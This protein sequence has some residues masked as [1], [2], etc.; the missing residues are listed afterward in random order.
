[1]APLFS[2]IIPV[3]NVEE[4]LDECLDSVL[5]QM[6]QDVSSLEI[7]LVDD[8]STDNSGVICD[9]YG[10]LHENIKVIHQ[11][12]QGLLGAR[13]TGYKSASG[14]YIINLDS[15]DL[16]AEKAVFSLMDAVNK[17]DADIVFFNISV[18][19]DA[20]IKPYYKDVFTSRTGC[21]ISKDQVVKAYF[22]YDIPVVTSMAGKIIKKDCFDIEY[23][24]SK[25]GRLSMGEDT[26]QTAEVVS[27][28]TT[29]YYLNQNLYIYRM[30]SGMTAKFDP[31]FYITFKQIISEVRNR[32]GFADKK[33]YA[34]FYNEKIVSSGCRAITQSKG[35][36]MRYLDRKKYIKGI[37][38]DRD[39]KNALSE[40]D[41]RTANIKNRY[42][43]IIWLSSIHAYLLIHVT[44]KLMR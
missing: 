15:D 4:Y 17:T 11:N 21:F 24:Y 20:E 22:N 42:K 37:I 6:N 38:K 34:R 27:R 44:L 29:Y 23:D 8:G 39:F 13:R 25:F 1:M 5:S 16:L 10:D 32:P 2:I 30:G 43:G 19:D 36:R 7:I 14:K 28:A 35:T 12:N 3:Y 18:L 9:K 40:I 26:L 33:E 31:E 41:L